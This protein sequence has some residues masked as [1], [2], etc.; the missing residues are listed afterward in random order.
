MQTTSTHPAQSTAIHFQQ[1]P[2]RCMSNVWKNWVRAF[3]LLF[4]VCA[5]NCA[6]LCAK[7]GIVSQEYVVLIQNSNLTG[8]HGVTQHQSQKEEEEIDDS[9][10]SCL[11]L[12]SQQGSPYASGDFI[13][14]LS[15]SRNWTVRSDGSRELDLT[16]ICKLHRYTAPQARQC[17]AD[18]HM[19]FVGDSLTRFQ[20]ISLVHLLQK[21]SFPP[22]FERAAR[23]KPCA[24]DADNKDAHAKN[25]LSVC[26]P[27]DEPNVCSEKEFIKTPFRDR[28]K[29][30]HHHVGGA[31][32]G[33][34]FDG[35][36]ECDCARSS[37]EFLC[38][39]DIPFGACEIENYLYRSKPD[40]EKPHHHAT[41]S[42][43]FE[44][45][46]GD[47][48]LPIRGM[49]FTD[50][51]KFGNCR[52]DENITDAKEKSASTLAYDWIETLEDA[53]TTNGTF[54]TRI[55]GVDY[56]IYN[57][58]LWGLLTQERAKR[59]MPLFRDL[60]TATGKVEHESRCFFKSTT[61]SARTSRRSIKRERGPIQQETKSA[62]C[63]Y[64]DFAQL[65]SEF[66]KIPDKE[67]AF[68]ER[69]AIYIDEI[70]FRPWVYEELN[71]VLLNV[72]CNS[73]MGPDSVSRKPAANKFT[74]SQFL[75]WSA[76]QQ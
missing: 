21:G 73:K 58:G 9:L 33:G 75:K 15:T 41:V 10:P 61:G 59:V 32:D 1:T 19:Q 60:I 63:S 48:P 11:S 8:H 31:L 62:G 29:S 38:P 13:T 35:Q 74:G 57:R 45:G 12:M 4:L 53:L 30:F 76:F 66:G 36:M 43:F 69:K 26:S 65:T 44:S 34:V 28:W 70:H 20:M 24:Y 68:P 27:P 40:V 17:L 14:D 52:R 2:F 56:A 42:F 64:L 47:T 5:L 37:V 54:R 7:S 6:L 18:R 23:N 16:A 46:W 39:P 25:M 72:I 50:C 3:C 55:P 51:S 22:R 49:D 67:G 71:N